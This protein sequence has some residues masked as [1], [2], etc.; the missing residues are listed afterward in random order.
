MY[1]PKRFYRR[2]YKQWLGGCG[3]RFGLWRVQRRVLEVK[4]ARRHRHWGG[5]VD[6]PGGLVRRRDRRGEGG[7]DVLPLTSGHRVV[8]ARRVWV[9][10]PEILKRQRPWRRHQVADGE[11]LVR[12]RRRRRGARCRAHLEI[13]GP[14]GRGMGPTLGKRQLLRLGRRDVV[15]REHRGDGG[16]RHVWEKRSWVATGAVGRRNASTFVCAIAKQSS[17]SPRQCARRGNW[18]WFQLRGDQ[19][20]LLEPG[21]F[22][23]QAQCP[24]AAVSASPRGPEWKALEVRPLGGDASV[25]DVNGWPMAR[26]QFKVD[27]SSLDGKG[28]FVHRSTRLGGKRPMLGERGEEGVDERFQ[29][30]PSGA[31]LTTRKAAAARFPPGVGCLMRWLW[32]RRGRRPRGC[33]VE[34]S[35]APWTYQSSDSI[36]HHPKLV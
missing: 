16:K 15:V 30:C 20:L 9:S 19:I 12:L 17:D 22:I 8:M 10:V 32:K 24:V 21:S 18:R 7:L 29:R 5:L 25:A 31:W 13:F 4:M 11:R 2:V 35:H 34:E 6:G 14:G 28:E 23:P 3:G 33:G 26:R 27:L 1:R 36:I